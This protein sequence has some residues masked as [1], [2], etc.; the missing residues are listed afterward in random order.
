MNYLETLRT[1]AE[2][3]LRPLADQVRKLAKQ[4]DTLRQREISE[5]EGLVQACDNVARL[6][7]LAG[8]YLEDGPGGFARF[9]TG[10]KR[11][12]AKEET[13]AET[14]K[15]LAGELVPAKK[16]E[17]EAARGQLERAYRAF[18]RDQLPA[19]ESRMADL[20]AQV[21]TEHDDFILAFEQLREDFGTLS[22]DGPP[23]VAANSRLS[24]IDRYG[25]GGLPWITFLPPPRAAAAPDAPATMP[26]VPVLVP[27]A[28]AENPPTAEVGESVTGD[29]PRAAVL[30]PEHGAD[31]NRARVLLRPPVAGDAGDVAPT[32]IEPPQEAPADLDPDPLAVDAEVNAELDAEAPPDAG[33]KE[34]LKIVAEGT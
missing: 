10:L 22:I 14:V 28:Q 18:Y 8:E 15:I 24:V 16:A 20:L 7:G 1:E 30:A 32:P 4:L 31:A 26:A 9:Q 11:A 5:T 13:S 6:K 25:M 3:K 23:P 2:K 33:G 27:P 17:L 12:M 34:N 21:V 29:G 19:C